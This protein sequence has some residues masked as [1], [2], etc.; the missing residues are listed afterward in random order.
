[1]QDF[2]PFEEGKD[3]PGFFTEAATAD[4]STFAQFFPVSFLAALIISLAANTTNTIIGMISPCSNQMSKSLK[5]E[6]SGILSLTPSYKAY[7]TRFE[8]SETIIIA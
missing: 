6:S 2:V 5:L 3:M 7:M 4:F 1:M 8:V